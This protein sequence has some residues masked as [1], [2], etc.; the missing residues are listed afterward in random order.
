MREA[1]AKDE[2]ERALAGWSTPEEVER[3][4][5]I[6]QL[7]FSD[8]CDALRENDLKYAEGLVSELVQSGR[9]KL[10]RMRALGSRPQTR[11]Q[12]ANRGPAGLSCDRSTLR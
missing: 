5:D 4:A 6:A 7:V 3:E 8:T 1:L 9:C 12:E 2:E 11:V 10:G